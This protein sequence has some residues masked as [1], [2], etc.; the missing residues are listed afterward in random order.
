MLTTADKSKYYA[1]MQ[2][3][4]AAKPKLICM[5]HEKCVQLIR[6]HLDGSHGSSLTLLVNAQNIIAQLERSL[7]QT[8]DVS[9]GLFYL[10][11]YC[12]CQ[13][14][15]SDTASLNSALNI[16]TSIRDTFEHL[17]KR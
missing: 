7:K 12:Y 6:Q 11:D 16:M 4:T 14:E 1:K 15:K 2:I 5:L 3:E 13:I 9:E 8:D 10:Y 17:A